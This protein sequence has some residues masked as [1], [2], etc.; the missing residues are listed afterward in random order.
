MIIKQGVHKTSMI[1]I[2][3]EAE[4]SRATLYNHFRDK[5][6]VIRALLE[7][8]VERILECG[9]AQSDPALS[10]ARISNEISSDKALAS[11][12]ISDPALLALMVTISSNA[13]WATIMAGLEKLVPESGELALRWL[14]G[15]CFAPLSSPQAQI[16]AET[17]VR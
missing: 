7:S 16:Q 17:L 14:I 5:E 8:E 11:M 4:V 13:L 15:Q 10:L 3:D 1:E 12:R 9:D 2:A 6:S